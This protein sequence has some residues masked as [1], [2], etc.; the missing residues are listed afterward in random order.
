[1]IV[2]DKVKKGLSVLHELY[3]TLIILEIYLI[4]LFQLYEVRITTIKLD[5][6]N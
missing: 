4:T 1:M 5:K 3:L 2:L 6:L